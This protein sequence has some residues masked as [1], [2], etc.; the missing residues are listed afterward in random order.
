MVQGLHLVATPQ[1]D[2]ELPTAETPEKSSC[3]SL[4][5]HTGSQVLTLVPRCHRWE[6]K[7]PA[8]ETCLNEKHWHCCQMGLDLNPLVLNF[9]WSPSSL[10]WAIWDMSCGAVPPLCM[11]RQPREMAGARLDQSSESLWR[12]SVLRPVANPLLHIMVA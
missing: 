4:P 3:T 6:C 7:A 5:S 2:T 10:Q 11:N 8:L 1:P 12:C 9:T